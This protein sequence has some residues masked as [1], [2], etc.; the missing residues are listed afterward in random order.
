MVMIPSVQIGHT[1]MKHSWLA[2]K[3]NEQILKVRFKFML[4][5]REKTPH[6][7]EACHHFQ[8]LFQSIQPINTPYK[9]ISRL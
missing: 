5:A 1:G 7:P 4:I 9:L 6:K 2:T 8:K 3:S